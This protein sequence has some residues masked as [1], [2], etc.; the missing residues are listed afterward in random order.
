M[1]ME[2]FVNVDCSS[3]FYILVIM[4]P[5]VIIELSDF[6][7]SCK[8]IK[9]SLIGDSLNEKIKKNIHIVLKISQQT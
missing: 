4:L 3:S 6:Y 1:Y 7:L 9:L 8:L 5:V 2:Y